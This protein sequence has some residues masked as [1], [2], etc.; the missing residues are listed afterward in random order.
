[1][2][3]ILA[4]ASPRRAELLTAA[5]FTFE[6]LPADVDETPRDGEP[7]ERYTERV[8][9][10][11][12]RQ[13]VQTVGETD[14]AVLGADTEVVADCRILGKPADLDHAKRMLEAL[15]GTVHDVLTAVVICANRREWVEVVT[16]RVHFLPMSQRDI[17]WYCA[18][19]EPMG[20]A[21]AYAIQGLGARFIDRIEGSW[22]NVVGLPLH[23]VHRLLGEVQ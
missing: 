21:G 20:K 2:R 23:A 7:P 18:S 5:G 10:D 22:S 19:G 4:S 15:S 17:D 3:L 13:V 14:I 9:R 8:A 11:K 12:A 16:T 6:V 1:V